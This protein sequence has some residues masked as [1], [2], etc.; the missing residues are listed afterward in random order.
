[1]DWFK[2]NKLTLNINKTECILFNNKLTP[3]TFEISIGENVINKYR[4]SK[5]SWNLDR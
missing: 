4:V 1:M 3:S 2:A 5:N